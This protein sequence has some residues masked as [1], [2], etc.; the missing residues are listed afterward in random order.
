[1]CE[2]Q[3]SLDPV[4]VLN[5]K[6]YYKEQAA[7]SIIGFGVSQCLLLELLKED[8]Y[9]IAAVDYAAKFAPFVHKAELG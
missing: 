8:G 5:L 4:L 9:E 7:K 3:A 1:V 2:E 6:L